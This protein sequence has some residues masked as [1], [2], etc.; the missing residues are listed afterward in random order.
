MEVIGRNELCEKTVAVTNYLFWDKVHVVFGIF[1]LNK[2]C[3]LFTKGYCG[4]EFFSHCIGL[5][6]IS[7]IVLIFD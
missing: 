3:N 7:E 2:K 5:I 6:P 4:Q 1:I